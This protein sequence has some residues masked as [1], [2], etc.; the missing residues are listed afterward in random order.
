MLTGKNLIACEPVDCAD[1]HY[2]ASGALAEFE[3]CRYRPADSFTLEASDSVRITNSGI[4]TLEN[5]VAVV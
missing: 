5:P 1:G 3:E 2:T 4:G